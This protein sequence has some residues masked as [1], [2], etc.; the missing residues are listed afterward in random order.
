M[1][2]IK[3]S[4]DVYLEEADELLSR[5]MYSK[6]VKNTIIS[7]LISLFKVLSTLSPTAPTTNTKF[8][9]LLAHVAT[10]MEKTINEFN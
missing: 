8:N 10:I 4:A 3:S 7:F 6:Q 2:F 1:Q 9:S 5:V